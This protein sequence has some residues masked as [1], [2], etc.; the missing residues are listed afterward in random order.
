MLA[1]VRHAISLPADQEAGWLFQTASSNDGNAYR[2]GIRR[3]CFVGV[4]LPALLAL[5]PL[6]VW[7]LGWRVAGAHALVGL[8]LGVAGCI[9]IARRTGGVFL[10]SPHEPS[11]TLRVRFPVYILVLV[12]TTYA[13]A[14]TECEALSAL[15]LL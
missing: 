3:G 8:V 15:G 10:V 7:L 12:A 14:W 1:G 11:D 2:R 6:Q 9:V 5:A 13:F 4:I